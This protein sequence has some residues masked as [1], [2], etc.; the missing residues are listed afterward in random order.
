MGPGPRP[1]ALRAVAPDIVVVGSI[2]HDLT[3]VTTR[4]PQAGE[5][6]LGTNHYTGGGGKGANQ[7]VAAARLG[8]RVALVGRVGEDEHGQTMIGALANEGIDVSSVG[9]DGEAPTGLAVITVDEH[10]ENT[11]V[12]SPGSNMRLL[13]PHLDEDLIAN[14]SVVLT[15]LEV[16][17]ET[18]A[19][20]AQLTTG[21][22]I[23][24]PAPGHHLPGELLDRVDVLVPN[25]TEL[26]I[27]AGRDVPKG[28]AEVEHAARSVG[29]DAAVVV[30]L[31]AEGALLVTPDRAKAF[32]APDVLP[33]DPTGAGDA[34]CA[35]IAHGLSAG[36][37]LPDAVGRAVI[38][39]ALAT[40]RPGAQAAM[41]TNDEVEAHLGR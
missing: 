30:T 33:V 5:T 8:A 17:I 2:N 1:L 36:M 13:P 23:L 26:G 3:V 32:P 6:V 4:L 37:D 39:G 15:Q 20:A 19:A 14:A 21:K 28:V 18:V 10:A 25:R 29:I 40:T 7:A 24:N 22:F 27:L 9:V 11:I 12:V 16:P 38:A 31:G 34:F 41:P 35:A